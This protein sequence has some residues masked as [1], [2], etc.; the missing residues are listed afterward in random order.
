M[1]AVKMKQWQFLMT[2]RQKASYFFF[3][4]KFVLAMS[5]IYRDFGFFNILQPAEIIFLSDVPGKL[6]AGL[7]VPGG[8]LVFASIIAICFILRYCF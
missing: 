7:S 2:V 6:T 1:M 8:I 3:I 5:N 4:I